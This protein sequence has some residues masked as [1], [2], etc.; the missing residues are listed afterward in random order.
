MAGSCAR[1]RKEQTSP[2]APDTAKFCAWMC[3]VWTFSRISTV[4]LSNSLH[5]EGSS[6]SQTPHSLAEVSSGNECLWAS[7]ISDLHASPAPPAPRWQIMKKALAWGGAF[8]LVSSSE[9]WEKQRLLCALARHMFLGFLE[10]GDK[11]SHPSSTL[12]QSSVGRW[13][14]FLVVPEWDDSLE[15]FL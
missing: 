12:W 1:W 9:A 15:S 10:M 8:T 14:A 11:V 5:S 4:L 6:P 2:L 3:S 7:L 13:A